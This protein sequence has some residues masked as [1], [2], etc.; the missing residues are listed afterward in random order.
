VPR[1]RGHVRSSSSRED[2]SLAGDVVQKLIR[3]QLADV[4]RIQGW[5]KATFDQSERNATL[6][7]AFCPPFEEVPTLTV[8]QTSGPECRIKTGQLLSYGVRL[9]LK[10]AL[11]GAEQVV[12]VIE[13]SAQ[14]PHRSAS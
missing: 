1:D 13:F 7:V 14:A 10:R 5:L 9:E 4:D 11:A 8:V 12:V 2:S 3:T 6:H